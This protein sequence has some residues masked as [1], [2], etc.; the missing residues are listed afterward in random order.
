[1]DLALDHFLQIGGHSV[2]KNWRNVLEVNFPIDQHKTGNPIN[3]GF[4]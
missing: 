3:M 2:S 4:A 1:M